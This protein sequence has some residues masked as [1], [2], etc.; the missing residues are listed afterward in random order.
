MYV[1]YS[2]SSVKIVT[3]IDADSDMYCGQRNVKQATT[4]KEMRLTL[5]SG[6]SKHPAIYQLSPH[7]SRLCTT[8]GRH[9]SHWHTNSPLERDLVQ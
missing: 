3:L 5:R 9:S 1:V 8:Y 7:E 6:D 2:S 4:L